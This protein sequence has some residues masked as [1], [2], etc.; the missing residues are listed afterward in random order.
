MGQSEL[1]HPA[2]SEKEGPLAPIHDAGTYGVVARVHSLF[3]GKV[4]L[5]AIGLRTSCVEYGCDRFAGYLR[6]LLPL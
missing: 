4:T 3:I 1:A 5:A 6:W 2:L